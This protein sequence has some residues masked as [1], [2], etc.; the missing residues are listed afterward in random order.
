MGSC[1][2]N[3]SEDATR[4]VISAVEETVNIAPNESAVS[5][6]SSL[7]L[8]SAS[9]AERGGTYTNADGRVQ[10]FHRVYPPRASAREDIRILTDLARR[11]GAD[12]EYKN[13]EAL[14]DEMS[15]GE[16]FF[17]GLTYRDIGETG[18]RVEGV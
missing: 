11:L 8:P 12:W 15:R 6:F 5:E 3:L 4:Q 1:L 2:G 10:R 18:H 13:E 17:S 7:V 16:P 9:F 14:F